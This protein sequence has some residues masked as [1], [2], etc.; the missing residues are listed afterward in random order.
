MLASSARVPATGC[1]LLWLEPT[2]CTHTVQAAP[3]QVLVAWRAAGFEAEMDGEL[4]VEPGERVK[5][6][7]DVGGWVRVVRLSD[8]KSGLVPSWAV[9]E[10]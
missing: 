10:A 8:H 7:S 5:V 6:H 4:S 2:A 3:H 9:G 1:S